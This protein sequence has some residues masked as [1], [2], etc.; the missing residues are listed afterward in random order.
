[1]RRVVVRAAV[2][3]A[4][5]SRRASVGA[6][7]GFS[8]TVCESRSPVFAVSSTPTDAPT[9]LCAKSADSGSSTVA[10]EPVW[11]AFA[12]LEVMVQAPDSRWALTTTGQ[13]EFNCTDSHLWRCQRCECWWDWEK[14]VCPFCQGKRGESFRCLAPSKPEAALDLLMRVIE[15]QSPGMLCSLLSLD[16]DGLHVRHAAAPNLPF[17][18][19]TAIDGAAIG[20]R[21]GSCGTA[22]FRRESVVVEDIAAD[23]LWEDYRTLALQHGLRACWSTPVFRNNGRVLG[24]FA[25]YS[26]KPARPTPAHAQL[27][28]TATHSAAPLLMS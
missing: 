19:L 7:P 4:P 25:L 5:D 21:A 24:V 23:P 28:Q 10:A 12:R 6:C 3:S 22:A 11:P 15:A 26:R 20:P 8:A 27:I 9:H 1:L 18:Y 14:A 2:E 17:S 16:S 13:Q